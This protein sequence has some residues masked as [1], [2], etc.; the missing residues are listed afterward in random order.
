[1]FSWSDRLPLLA[2]INLNIKGT[3][4]LEGQRP[5]PQLQPA[6]AADFIRQQLFNAYTASGQNGRGGQIFFVGHSDQQ[7]V[8][9]SFSILLY[10]AW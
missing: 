9:T 8:A 7:T 1:M 4:T 5:R 6:I 3:D 10:G 2:M